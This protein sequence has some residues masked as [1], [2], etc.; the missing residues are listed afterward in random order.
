MPEISEKQKKRARKSALFAACIVALFAFAFVGLISFLND[1]ADEL[2]YSR[3]QTF[4][5]AVPTE[6]FYL[7]LIGNDSRKGSALY[8]GKSEE[9]SQVDQYADIITLVR[10]DPTEYKITLL[11]IPRD[12]VLAGEHEKINAS[13][14]SGDPEDVVKQVEKL[15]GVY[16]DF[17]M[18]TGFITFE[19]LINALGGI[20]VYVP[21]QISLPDPAN[22]KRVTVKAG[23][24]NLD[25]SKALV[26]ARFRSTYG[27]N[28]EALRQVNVRSIERAMIEK[29]LEMQGDIDLAHIVASLDNDTK[30]NAYIPL[31]GS[32]ILDFV[33][34]GDQV[35]FYSGT[36]PYAVQ[37]RDDDGAAIIAEDSKKWREIMRA[38]DKGNDP[39]NI[40]QPPVFTN[41]KEKIE[42]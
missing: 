42:E 20:N 36:G 17:Y 8:T 33:K 22:G 9:H 10:I 7:L 5:S 4:A 6:P 38:V 16:I 24:Q 39:A 21:R 30:T 18:M 1:V 3:G 15:T 35:T 19:N 14:R 40:I 26:L 25:G 31:L 27:E 32:V 11:S 28:E 37:T 2:D 41:E 13:L 23:L 12:T 29:V 34:H